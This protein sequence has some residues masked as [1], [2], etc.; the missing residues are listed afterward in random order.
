MRLANF[1][2]C[3]A[4]NGIEPS[5]VTH[6]ASRLGSVSRSRTY[7]R[8]RWRCSI[9]SKLKLISYIWILAL[10]YIFI[11]L[12]SKCDWALTV[13]LWSSTSSLIVEKYIN[14]FFSKNNKIIIKIYIFI[15]KRNFSL[16]SWLVALTIYPIA[17]YKN[18]YFYKK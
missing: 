18:L 12:G 9:N 17:F 4:V 13:G 11:F 16:P 8:Q 5:R 2:F 7:S 14:Y 15:K 1:L 6:N 3:L 10:M